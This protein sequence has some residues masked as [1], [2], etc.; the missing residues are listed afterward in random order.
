VRRLIVT[1]STGGVEGI[2]SI[3]DVILNSRATFS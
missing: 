2:L 3:D 1:D